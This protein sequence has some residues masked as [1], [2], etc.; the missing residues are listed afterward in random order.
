VVKVTFAKAADYSCLHSANVLQL[1]LQFQQ[2]LATNG[3]AFGGIGMDL[4]PGCP[5]GQTQVAQLQHAGRLRQQQDL[6]KQLFEF[7]Q[8]G[9]AK[10][11]D[12]VM[13]RMQ[14]PRNEAKGQ[15]LI[16]RL[17]QLTRTDDS[18]K[19]PVAYP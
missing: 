7:G 19:T 11:V 10:M 4:C 17:L 9:F 14:V 15:A 16:G 2:S 8:K 12:R 1:M 6:H 5:L 18:L 3:L 13:V